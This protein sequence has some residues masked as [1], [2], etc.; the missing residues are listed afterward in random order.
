VALTVGVF[1]AVG[2][3]LTIGDGDGETFWV[4]LTVGVVARVGD[5]LT[6]DDADPF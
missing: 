6:V 1:A 2:D 4:A 3:V 5:V